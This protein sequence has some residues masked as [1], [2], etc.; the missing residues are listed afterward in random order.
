MWRG[1][2]PGQPAKLWKRTVWPCPTVRIAMEPQL[3]VRESRGQLTSS[4]PEWD[5]GSCIPLG[6]DE[7][8]EA[9]QRRRSGLFN[10]WCSNHWAFTL[11]KKNPDL[12]PFIKKINLVEHKS[13][14]KMWTTAYRGTWEEMWVTL[15]LVTVLQIQRR[16]HS[17]WKK[18]LTL[19]KYG[20]TAVFCKDT[21]KAM[22]RQSTDFGKITSVH[23][24]DKRLVSK[25]HK[26][27]NNEQTTQ[28][29]NKQM[30]GT[31]TLP[32]KLYRR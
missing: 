13:K 12:K 18:R 16:K 5:V 11:Q 30:V 26:E 14:C 20:T 22:T 21:V 19:W 15:S 29:K 27:L 3:R 31:D 2:D 24:S 4:H 9:I 7:T 17:P 6:S 28:F 1:T 23:T 10:K 8:A 32:N 25:T